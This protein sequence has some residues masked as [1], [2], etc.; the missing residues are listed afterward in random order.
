MISIPRFIS[1]VP[2][3]FL[4]IACLILCVLLC[5]V[6][7]LAKDEQKKPDYEQYSGRAITAITYSGLKFTK[8]FVVEREI[9]SQVGE[10]FNPTLAGE[11]LQRLLDL[12]I[13]G[14]VVLTV[15]P[16]GDGV[17][18]DFEINELPR[19]IPYPSLK[20]S[21]ENGFSIGAG[22]AAPNF[23]G[24]AIKFSIR[25]LFGGSTIFGFAV[26]NPWITGNHVSGGLRLSRNVRQ[27]ELLNFEETDD[28]AQLF[29]GAFLGKH[30]RLDGYVGY[31]GVKSN[32]DGITLDPS[33]R[34]KMFVA[35]A[36]L[37][38]D[39]RNAKNAPTSGWMNQLINVSYFGVDAN[40]FAFQVDVNRYLQLSDNHSF[41]LGPLFTYQTGEVGVDVPPYLQ[42]FMGGANTIRGYKLI[43]LGKEIYGKNQLLYNLEYRWNFIPLKPYKIIRWKL[44]LGLQLA[45]F[46]DVGT[47]WT[48]SQDL[49]L[50]RTKLGAG[51]GLRFLVPVFEMIRLDVG[52]SQY[53]D[54]AFN[55]GV[56][57][58]FFGRRLRVR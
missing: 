30:G 55:F 20:Y 7:V 44:N 52:V 36:Q 33:D 29:G 4:I 2:G 57:S 49:S 16:A 3:R 15:E 23:T 17:A 27:N 46:T 58:I 13:F 1:G 35:N 38:Y 19:L 18:M 31:L 21:E 6:G 40:F 11:D 47:A 41:A 54:F 10:P 56:Q 9:H 22:L 32:K 43:E 39:N 50:N 34:D 53:G 28:I 48:R 45:G 51:A 12:P 14:A 42:Y 5:S 37:G 25:A 8:L 24:R 26:S